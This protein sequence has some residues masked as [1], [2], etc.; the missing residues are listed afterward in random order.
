MTILERQERASVRWHPGGS[1]AQRRF[2]AFGG[3]ALMVLG[4]QYVSP[5]ASLDTWV[6]VAVVVI[7]IGVGFAV[8]RWWVLLWAGVWFLIPLLPSSSDRSD[9]L[10]AFVTLIGV[11]S[12][13]LSLGV[14][15]ACR[16]ALSR[17]HRRWP[18]GS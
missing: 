8:G 7:T 9:N 16:G 3:Y 18:A 5:A 2:L 11:P 6:S 15:A 4:V 14:G 17:W 12:A 1:T 13:A 10:I